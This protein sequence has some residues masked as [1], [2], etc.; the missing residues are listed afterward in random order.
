NMGIA[1]P[2]LDRGLIASGAQVFVDGKQAAELNFDDIGRT[3][4]PYSFLLMVPQ[5]DIEA[6][7]VDDLRRLGIAV[8]HQ[9]EVLGLE[10][11][12]D[13]VVARA[14]TKS[15]SPLEIRSSYLI[16]ADGAHSIVRKSLGLSFE[17]A[18]YPHTFL[19]ADCKIDW[20][21]DYDHLK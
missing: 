13:D 8:E 19:L 5:W 1:E 14:T 7:L 10:Q 2:L 21:L 6:I 12:A 3:D 9:V 16:G 11:S 4:T 18:P 15:G 17:G 20:P